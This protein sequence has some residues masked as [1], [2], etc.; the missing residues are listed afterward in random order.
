[1]CV[2]M[3]A[4]ECRIRGNY[5]LQSGNGCFPLR[6]SGISLSESILLTYIHTVNKQHNLHVCR[7]SLYVRMY[8]CMSVCMYVLMVICNAH[9]QVGDGGISVRDGS[10]LI[11]KELE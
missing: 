8:V 3:S 11:Y 5:N 10:L 1:M 2:E 9:F 4:Y 6:D 7:N